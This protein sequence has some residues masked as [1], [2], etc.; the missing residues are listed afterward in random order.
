MIGMG[1]RQRADASAPFQSLS[2]AALPPC[3]KKVM[4]ELPGFWSLCSLHLADG[5]ALLC[6]SSA[7]RGPI[8]DSS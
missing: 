5:F 4:V 6:R 7:S 8:C 3:K 2:A 1:R